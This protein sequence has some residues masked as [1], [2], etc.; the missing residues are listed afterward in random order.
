MPAMTRLLVP[1]VAVLLCACR[2]APHDPLFADPPRDA[3]NPA[4]AAVLHIPSGGVEIN[5]LA[6]LASGA[7][8]HPTLV[9]CHGWP[10]NEKNLDLAHAL[11]RAGWNTVTFN[12]RGSWGSPGEFRFAQVPQDVAAVLAYLRS[13]EVAQRL[14]V[15]VRRIV[16]AGH[17]MGGWATAHA[18]AADVRLSGA[19]LIAAAD[20]G[21]VG[22]KPRPELVQQAAGN[23]ETLAGT[24]PE[25]MADE[26]AASVSAFGLP[27]LAPRLAGMPL[28]L[29]T[30]DD[31]L[32]EHSAALA[33]AIT[34]AGGSVVRR[35]HFATDHGWSD[36]RVAL[37]VAILE[38][39]RALPGS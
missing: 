10:G 28:L 11:R 34:A 5:G 3:T 32:A 35:R 15:D 29:L 24:S 33:S 25:K 8:P 16:L 2:S 26:L 36:S 37:Q 1:V 4:R 38:W 12:Y 27:Q 18:A 22:A 31:G 14:R 17:S 7:G 23:S 19:I 13:P 6:Y 20:L 39:L 9:L 30:S 21:I